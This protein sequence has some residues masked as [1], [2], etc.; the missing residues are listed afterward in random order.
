MT[1]EAPSSTCTPAM[2]ERSACLS[3]RPAHHGGRF[4]VDWLLNYAGVLGPALTA[5]ALIPIMV[6]GL[7]SQAYGL[8]IT[9]GAITSLLGGLDLGLGAAVAREAGVARGA[10]ADISASTQQFILAAGNVSIL[11]AASCTAI[12]TVA[13]LPLSGPLHLTPPLR[14]IVPLVFFLAGIGFLGDW[15]FEYARAVLVGLG[16][17][18]LVALLGAS[19][20]L[21]R[22]AGVILLL[23]FRNSLVPVAIWW[24]ACQLMLALL[25]LVAVGR[26]EPCYSFR[27]R[28]PR[29]PA[30]APYLPFSL[31]SLLANALSN[32]F[33]Q[34]PV[35]MIPFLR[36]S[37][38]LVPYY[39]GQK[40]PLAT[41]GFTHSG[42][43]VLY[44]SSSASSTS[45][46]MEADRGMLVAAMRWNCI[47]VIPLLI[48]LAAFAPTLFQVW[49]GQPP[50]AETVAVMRFVSMAAFL[51]SMCVPILYFMWGRGLIRQTLPVFVIGVVASAVANLLLVP[52]YGVTGAAAG[53]LLGALVMELPL[54]VIAS[55]FCGMSPAGFLGSLRGFAVPGA[56]CV[57]TSLMARRFA[58]PSNW[59]SLFGSALPAAIAFLVSFYLWGTSEEERMKVR[60]LLQ[61][62][63]ARSLRLASAVCKP[64]D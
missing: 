37:A 36:G 41:L 46:N 24:A 28:W 55:R 19:G 35:L 62:F 12:M 50:T 53:L 13:A 52:S 27:P 43:D 3:P 48:G 58:A 45:E 49:L 16:R 11:M 25:S 40:F 21:L 34:V 60:G 31:T 22:A 26:I 10:G 5:V 39:L 15:L 51:D 59:F 61:P 32:L 6:R 38:A 44:A 57:A 2:A 18:S 20:A 64:A 1:S 7:G 23:H 30:L 29:W 14:D 9:A 56:L 54:I 42:G 47:F 8:W 4:V 17:F 63:A 33:W